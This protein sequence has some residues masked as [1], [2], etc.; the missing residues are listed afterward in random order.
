MFYK[1]LRFAQDD[2]YAIVIPSLSALL[3]NVLKDV[4]TKSGIGYH[5]SIGNVLKD[6][7]TKSG[8]GYHLSIGNV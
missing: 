4:L 8:I 2:K 7:L 1:I 5:L 3:W 6:A